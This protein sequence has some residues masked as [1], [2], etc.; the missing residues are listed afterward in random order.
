MSTSATAAS[1][2]QVIPSLSDDQ[3]QCSSIGVRQPGQHRCRLHEEPARTSGT[4]YGDERYFTANGR[5]SYGD[6]PPA[7]SAGRAWALL[8]A[9]AG[10][11]SR[12]RDIANRLAYVRSSD[13]LPLVRPPTEPSRAARLAR[14]TGRCGDG[15]GSPCSRWHGRLGTRADQRWH[16]HEFDELLKSLQDLNAL[17]RSDPC[18]AVSRFLFDD[19][20]AMPVPPAGWVRSVVLSQHSGHVVD[21]S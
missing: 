3:V 1:S 19:Q 12:K 16:G 4:R 9:N 17:C 13:P 20:P 5:K 11:R 7:D 8:Y 2:P 15:A 14:M 21:L 18:A 6:G 10:C